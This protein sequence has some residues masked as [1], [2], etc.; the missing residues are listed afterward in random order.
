MVTQDW[1][2][3]CSLGQQGKKNQVKKKRHM[4]TTK[5]LRRRIRCVTIRNR[6]VSS[7]TLFQNC[8]LV[9]RDLKSP[10]NGP[11]L[12]KNNMLKCCEI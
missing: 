10:N 8:N 1:T 2:P 7:A 4:G 5:E 11:S 9:L 3:K 6:L 12:N